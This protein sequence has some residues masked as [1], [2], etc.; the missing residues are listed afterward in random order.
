MCYSCGSVLKFER[1]INCFQFMSVSAWTTYLSVN[2]EKNLHVHVCMEL[3]KNLYILPN[4][5]VLWSNVQILWTNELN[6][7]EKCSHWIVTEEY[8]YLCKE[9]IHEGLGGRSR[10][11]GTR[12]WPGG[13]WVV[14]WVVLVTA[15]LLLVYFQSLL[16]LP[17]HLIFIVIW[18][19][20]W[21]VK[22]I[23][24]FSL[25]VQLHI[26]KVEPSANL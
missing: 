22:S 17:Y 7:H 24:L 18:E 13:W 20:V 14:V 9:M 8:K 25:L 6:L 1:N 15:A 10:I 21:Q 23:I 5:L 26:S 3:D 11:Q 2:A 16:I 12:P 19:I 4:I